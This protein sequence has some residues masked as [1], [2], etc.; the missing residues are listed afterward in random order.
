MELENNKLIRRCLAGE[1]SAQRELYE[2]YRVPLFRVCL[3]YANDRAEAEDMLQEGFIKIFQDL[4]HYRG[5]GAFGGWM[6]KVVVN[7]AL[8][9]IRKRKKLFPPIDLQEVHEKFQTDED[10][11]SDLN[12]QA[13]TQL[14]QQLPPGYRAVFNLYVIE[15]FSHKEIAAQLGITPSTSK[16]QLF[17]A[18][19][20]L[21]GMLEKL[22]IS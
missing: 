22:I 17:K 5:A 18:K 6:R 12:A 11:H 20:T 10:I 16:S 1:T 14:V 2:A 9:H 4:K 7:I 21:R 8:Q 19:A 3:R 13:L 15:G